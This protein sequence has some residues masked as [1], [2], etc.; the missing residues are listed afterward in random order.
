[1][2]AQTGTITV[3][4]GFWVPFLPR[5]CDNPPREHHAKKAERLICRSRAWA[6]DGHRII[7]TVA[8]DHL[9]ETIRVMCALALA[10]AIE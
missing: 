6:R 2:Q 1:M 9:D 3:P 8:E 10:E 4:S 5:V 7:P